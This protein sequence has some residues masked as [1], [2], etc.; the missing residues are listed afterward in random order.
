MVGAMS[1]DARGREVLEYFPCRYDG[2]QTHF[3]GPR[4]RPGTD[5]IAFL[6]GTETY[7]KFVP[8]P[9]PALVEDLLGVTCVNLGLPNA[10][11]DVCLNDGAIARLTAGAR[12]VVIQAMGAHNLSNRYY[13]VHPRRNDR[14]LGAS[15]L[16]RM[17]Y[18]DRDFT[19]FNFTR[20]L[21]GAL[22]RDGSDRFAMLVAE[23]QDAWVGRMGALLDRLS[24]PAVLLWFGAEPPPEQAG[25]RVVAPAPLFVTRMMID[26]LR[27]G[28]AGVV[29]VAIGDLPRAEPG[30]GMVFDPVDAAAAADLLG[31]PAHRACAGALAPVLAGLIGAQVPDGQ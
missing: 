28:L 20:H 10:G 2:S 29:E 27:P 7:G 1:I 26:A 14:F 30:A 6:G 11:V 23:L 18:R 5:Y 9:Y 31:P 25:M 12:A 4:R 8:R 17:V 24:C 13:A 15:E 22:E 16:M 19:D 3:R 21:L